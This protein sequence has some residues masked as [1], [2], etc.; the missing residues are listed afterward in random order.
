LYQ[1][2]Y[3]ENILQM[4]RMVNCKSNKVPRVEGTQSLILHMSD[5]KM[6]VIIYKKITGKL[7]QF[8]NTKLYMN[9]SVNA[10]FLVELELPHF[11]IVKHIF[12]YI[13]SIANYGILYRKRHNIDL[14]VFVN[15][16]WVG[17]I[18]FRRST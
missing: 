6:D 2:P 15:V 13:K 8:I 14:E 7:I 5:Q 3:I 11:N 12:S 4:L 9:S 10:W 16:D 17:D 1:Q 18:K